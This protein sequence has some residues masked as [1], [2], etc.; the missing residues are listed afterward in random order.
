MVNYEAMQK[1]TYDTVVGRP[2][3]RIPGLPTWEQK[4]TFLEEAQESAMEMVV[5]YDWA[6]D[7]GLLPEVIGSIKFLSLTSKN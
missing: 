5:S 3:T 2:F 1:D 4:E 7:H 6:G